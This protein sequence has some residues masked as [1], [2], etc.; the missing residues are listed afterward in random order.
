MENKKRKFNVFKKKEKKKVEISYISVIVLIMA[1]T[2]GAGIFFKNKTLSEMAQGNFG[3]V[4]ATWGVGIFAMLALALALVEVTSTQKSNR[5]TLEWVKIFTPQWFHKSSINYMKWIYVPVTLFTM[6]IYVTNALEDAGLHMLTETNALLFSFA[7]FLWFMI[8]NLFSLRFSIFTQWV[9]TI[10]QLVPLLILPIIGFAHFGDVAGGPGATIINKHL[11]ANEG[12]VGASP[13]LATI[14]GVSAIAFAYDGFYTAASLRNDLK[15]PKD[16]GKGLVGGV[17]GISITYLFLT[18]GFNVAGDGDIYGMQKFM[19]SGLYKM[20]NVFV[21][22]GVM[23]VVNSYAMT[24]PKQ[25][26]DLEKEGDGSEITWLHKLIYRKKYNANDEKQKAFSAWLWIFLTTVLLFA[27][28]GPIGAYGFTII[29]GYGIQYGGD[30]LYAF[31]DVLVNYTSLLIFI[32]IVTAVLGALINRK[33]KK[34]KVIKYKWFV[35]A[36]ICAII[37]NY[38]AGLYMIIE[39]IVNIAGYRITDPIEIKAYVIE[40]I[41]FVVILAICI[42]P[43]LWTT[44]LSKNNKKSKPNVVEVSTLKNQ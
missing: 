41:L 17:I 27:I 38:A 10:L 28:A 13:W 11:P 39:A 22:V 20:F 30:H 23:G 42:L 8:I 35:P 1:G 43:A 5:G 14:A 44:Y 25:F 33:T 18:I 40:L 24:S 26:V 12:L 19:S 2:I 15:K 3:I 9:S 7:I 37:I 29:N 31:C 34:V 4:M 16:I 6:P 32:I 21:A 36:A